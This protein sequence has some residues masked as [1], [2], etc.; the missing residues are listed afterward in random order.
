MLPTHRPNENDLRLES[1]SNLPQGQF[2]IS[3]EMTELDEM[4]I[5]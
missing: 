1:K 2:V 5:D 4:G 3:T